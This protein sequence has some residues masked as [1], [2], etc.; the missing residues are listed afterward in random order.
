MEKIFV[1]IN[2]IFSILVTE[3]IPIPIDKQMH[4]IS[5]SFGAFLLSILISAWAILVISILAGFKEYYDYNHPNIH[6]Y[7]V[8]DFIASVIGSVFGYLV[9][10]ILIG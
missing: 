3:K 1:L 4:F 6:T 9:F 10:Y 5:G 7:D 2:N 8:W